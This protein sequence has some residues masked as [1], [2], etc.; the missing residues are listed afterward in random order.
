MKKTVRAD[1]NVKQSSALAQALVAGLL[2]GLGERYGDN[3]IKAEGLLLLVSTV[4]SSR[5]RL[6]QLFKGYVRQDTLSILAVE[7]D[8]VCAAKD[9][10][11]GFQIHTF[12][13]H[14]RCFL[15]LLVDLEEAGGLTGRFRHGLLL[16]GP[17]GL[18]DTLGFAPR[19][20]NNLVGVGAS[21][22]LQALFVGARCL[23][24]SESVYHLGRGINL[25]Q[26][27]L[28]DADPDAVGIENVLC[29]FL[30]RLFSLLPCASEE[31]LDVRSADNV[32]HG[33][34]RHLLHGDVGLLDVE[35]IFLRVLDAPEDYEINGRNRER[36]ASISAPPVPSL[37]ARR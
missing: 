11:H 31:R 22:V 28:I 15:V 21:F 17:R 37:A 4:R 9:A 13:G 25:L 33:A 32:T 23:Y 16:I 18:Q 36:L 3:R 6:A 35:E 14:L 1:A 19:F 10:F 20:R 2:L 29:Q 12:A 7:D 24:V 5:L 8:L 26:L 30:H 34:L 27:D